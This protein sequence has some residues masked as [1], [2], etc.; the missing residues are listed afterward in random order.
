MSNVDS[1]LGRID[2]EFDAAKK[3]IEQFQQDKL[4]DYQQ[5]Q[6][7]MATFTSLCDRLRDIWKPRL[8]ALAER[9]GQKVD[10]KPLVT[11]LLRQAKFQFQ[12]QLAKIVLTIS[13]MA[14]S[15][16]RNLVLQYDLEILPILM[17][18]KN[19]DHLEMPLDQVDENAIAG[20]IDDRLLDFVKTYLA[21]HEDQHYLTYLK[22]YQV[23][24][25]VANVQFPKY[26]AAT[27]CEWN[28]K[29]YYFIGEQTCQEFRKKNG[30]ST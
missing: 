10:V 26:A 24:D 29:T 8:E 17:R 14:D 15:D 3:R 19:T 30:I 28:G 20:W 12:S 25:P 16:V 21:L 1:L 7:R 27:T 6:A 18:F 13:A 11:P 5:R 2:A 9:F 22:E 4:T 23:T